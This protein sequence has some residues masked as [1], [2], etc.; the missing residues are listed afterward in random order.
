MGYILSNIM[1][2]ILAVSVEK[3]VCFL[4]FMSSLHEVNG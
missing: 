4:Y 3:E 2:R 1:F